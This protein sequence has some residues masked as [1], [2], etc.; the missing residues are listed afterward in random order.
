MDSKKKSI[1]KIGFGIAI[2][3]LI[4]WIWAIFIRNKLNLTSV[5]NTIIGIIVLYVIGLFLFKLIIKN[6]PNY[7]IEKGKISLKELVLCFLLQF[8]SILVMSVL[9][10]ILSKITGNEIGGEIDALTPL[11]LFQLLIFNPIIEE[12]VFRKLFADKLL[13]HGE[14]LFMLTSSFCFSIVHGVS[15]GIPQILYTFILGMIWSYVYIKSGNLLVPIILHSLSNLFGSVI[16]QSLQS[17]SQIAVSIYSMCIMLM[18]IVGIILFLSNKKKIKID[19]DNKLIT[20]LA[21]KDI[22]FNKGILFYIIITIT[23]FI[24]KNI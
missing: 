14:L 22:F 4:S 20:K 18:G 24:F 12:Y 8:S 2:M 17:V 13:K 15:L 19:N 21:L 9:T 7:K 5:Q 3:F 1:E 11:M 16:I 23:M 6:I 10:V